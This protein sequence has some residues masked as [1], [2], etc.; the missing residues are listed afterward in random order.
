MQNS[1][2][3]RGIKKIIITIIIIQRTSARRAARLVPQVVSCN[4]VV[5]VSGDI[6]L[7]LLLLLFYSVSDHCINNNNNTCTVGCAL[8]AYLAII[9]CNI[10]GGG[11]RSIYIIFKTR[12]C[13]VTTRESRVGECIRLLLLLL[14]LSTRFRGRVGDGRK[15]D[16]AVRNPYELQFYAN[17]AANSRRCRYMHSRTCSGIPARIHTQ[18]YLILAHIHTCVT[19]VSEC[20]IH[21]SNKIYIR[22]QGVRRR[23]T[24]FYISYI[25]S[26]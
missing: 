14:L 1:F 4:V 7:L 3:R 25:I 23:F 22:I 11:V 20:D 26:V 13:V 9:F 2:Y 8:R 19:S 5:A 17:S 21:A 15:S 12:L 16:N 18:T 24:Q 6:F 10:H